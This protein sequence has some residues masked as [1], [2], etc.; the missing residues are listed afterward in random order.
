MFRPN[1]QLLTSDL[2]S[3]LKTTS[4]K[5]VLLND[6]IKYADVEAPI[7]THLEFKIS[8]QGLKSFSSMFVGELI[9]YEDALNF[10]SKLNSHMGGELVLLKGIG[11]LDVQHV[12]KEEEEWCKAVF[13][14]VRR[15]SPYEVSKEWLAWIRCSRMPVQAWTKDFFN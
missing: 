15:W 1:T 9:N 4:W 8:E 3:D 13:Q 10:Q 14:E 2:N 6:K 5:D 11:G 12:F 7:R